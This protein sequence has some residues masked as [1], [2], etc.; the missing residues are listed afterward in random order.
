M[1]WV[2]GCQLDGESACVCVC[3]EH[4]QRRS[5]AFTSKLRPLFTQINS[6]QLSHL[7]SV[8]CAAAESAG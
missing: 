8:K 4:I 1:G 7:I 5:G 6:L 2:I 3:E